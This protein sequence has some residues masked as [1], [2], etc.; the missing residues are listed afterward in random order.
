[1]KKTK[2]LLALILVMVMVFAFAPGLA[3][4]GP[5]DMNVDDYLD[6]EDIPSSRRQAID[7][8]TALGILTGYETTGGFEFRGDRNVT[9]AEAAKII[10]YILLGT[11]PADRLVQT[12]TQFTDVPAAHWA[13]GFIAYC[14]S[15]GIIDG[16]PNGTFLPDAN[17]TG[18]QIAKMLLIALGYGQNG[19]YVG[20]NWQINAIV[21]GQRNHRVT[22]TAP[23][24]PNFG[25]VAVLTGNAD[26]SAPATRYEIAAYTFNAIRK[27]MVDYSP[28]F[29]YLS[30]YELGLSQLGPMISIA[31]KNFDLA[32]RVRT[33]EFGY[34]WLYYHRGNINRPLTDE[35][36]SGF[37][38]D[39]FIATADHTKNFMSANYQ[40]PEDWN[41]TE[42][43]GYGSTG[44]RY[45]I[46]GY[47]DWIATETSL[48]LKGSNTP[49]FP[50]G[51]HVT[52]FSGIH[53]VVS[54]IIIEYE[55]LGRV[56][57]VNANNGTISANVYEA[58]NN[59]TT[60]YAP[61]IFAEGFV[62]NDWILIYPK[63]GGANGFSGIDPETGSSGQTLRVTAAETV[64]G[65]AQSTTG[66]YPTSGAFLNGRHTITVDG[67]TRNLAAAI[68]YGF[69]SGG[70]GFTDSST[71]YLDSFGSIVGYEAAVPFTGEASL[72]YAFV[73][74]VGSQTGLGV[75][76]RRSVAM[77]TTDGKYH[78]LPIAQFRPSG[79]G[80]TA[81][82]AVLAYSGDNRY[83]TSGASTLL[84]YPVSIGNTDI[85]GSLLGTSPNQ[86]HS[87]KWFSYIITDD[88]EVILKELATNV[89]APATVQISWANSVVTFAGAGQTFG[90]N[91]PWT[92]R[93]LN[94][95][96]NLTF[97]EDGSVRRYEG[98]SRWPRGE[99]F[100]PSAM[101]SGGVFKTALIVLAQT[102][103]DIEDSKTTAGGKTTTTS[104]AQIYVIDSAEGFGDATYG[105]MVEQ[106]GDYGS[107]EV[108]S[109]LTVDG[110]AD[111][112][113]YK[114]AGSSN[115]NAV[116][117][118]VVKIALRDGT[119]DIYN[120]VTYNGDG[121]NTGYGSL[122]RPAPFTAGNFESADSNS[123]I[124]TSTDV[125]T[126]NAD[127]LFLRW[128][129]AMDEYYLNMPQKGATLV[130]DD[131]IFVI[132]A[133]VAGV[134]DIAVAVISISAP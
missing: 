54:K 132:S 14:A 76:N 120:V 117:N 40:W 79:T 47:E 56:T 80:S 121:T 86:Y 68:G 66:A 113:I 70:P 50:Y 7:V 12:N 74:D 123:I 62:R 125:F 24:T 100:T 49:V 118:D 126:V 134:D 42:N 58:G 124:I 1:M 52:I 41:S 87:G 84:A 94:A 6:Y 2:R 25:A 97:A 67:T 91:G 8:L 90:T 95:S 93:A 82:P 11:A 65:R 71:F 64:T 119:T 21:D 130:E 131:W 10:S 35:Y 26:F 53:D 44:L 89:V 31:R 63:D 133:V 18:A 46:N 39:S 32:T 59:F 98:A 60:G 48:V 37:I 75:G 22:G 27:N 115:I 61:T 55:L 29:G 104:I 129:F 92:T 111:T 43:G 102:Q 109:V 19:E 127:T 4:A 16:Y 28:F 78:E 3:S 83:P 99:T 20:N 122:V 128:N 105:I 85:A 101:T 23:N 15:R 13:S 34:E 45:F 107:Y 69:G 9:R 57:G 114:A 33:D 108:W 72:Q 30:G 51:A 116:E 17:V 103:D 73:V 36:A 88:G 110:I 96:S 77:Y 38:V 5:A 112:K 106:L 81:Q